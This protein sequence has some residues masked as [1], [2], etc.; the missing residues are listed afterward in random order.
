VG[1]NIL[2]IKLIGIIVFMLI[3]ATTLP[4]VGIFNEPYES[5]IGGKGG[6]QRQLPSLPGSTMPSFLESEISLGWQVFDDFSGLSGAICH[7][8]WWGF[9]VIKDNDTWLPGNPDDMEFEITL[10]ED[11]GGEPGSEVFKFES[12]IPEIIGTGIIYDYPDGSFELYHFE[13]DLGIC[14]D[15][16]NGWISI[17]SKN[18]PTESVLGWIESPDGNGKVFHN[19]NEIDMDVSF[20]LAE[21]GDPVIEISISGGLGVS[22]GITNIGNDTIS[23]IPVDIV[24]FGGLLSKTKINNRETISLEPGETVTV[25][26]GLFFGLGSIKIGVIADDV[27]E[28]TSGNHLI[29][30]SLI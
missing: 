14:L 25:K 8:H 1:V 7:A 4:V 24:V 9:T 3:S 10:F 26:S 29:V 16:P 12:I 13:A 21:A 11:D 27:V 28:Y 30:F 2:K 19:D 5:P 15:L 6:L 23:D 18:S 22:A 17:N 20:I